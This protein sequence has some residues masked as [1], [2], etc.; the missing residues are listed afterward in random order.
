MDSGTRNQGNWSP[1]SQFQ[2]GSAAASS[3][4][5]DA[6]AH[7][8][9]WKNKV[10]CTEWFRFGGACWSGLEFSWTAKQ[11]IICRQTAQHHESGP[12][13]LPQCPLHLFAFSL[14]RF[15]FVLPQGCAMPV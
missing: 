10:I 14:L 3:L 5:L 13:E 2:V 4:S 11:P 7:V 6:K 12:G 9:M 8:Q 15:F 1:T